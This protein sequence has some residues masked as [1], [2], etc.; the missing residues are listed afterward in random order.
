[1]S[2]VKHELT[3]AEAQQIANGTYDRVFGTP[4]DG[5]ARV[6]GARRA[7]NA[8]THDP[9]KML[10]R[11]KAAGRHVKQAREVMGQFGSPDLDR[12]KS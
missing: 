1:V 3:L 7:N 12:F 11:A 6:I 4:E 10:E 9:S 2:K 5:E 8:K